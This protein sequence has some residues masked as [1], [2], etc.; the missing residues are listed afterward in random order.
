MQ[1]EARSY[2]LTVDADGRSA[3]ACELTES[4]IH[5]EESAAARKLVAQHTHVNELM[6]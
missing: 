4:L 2:S 6:P 3:S 5:C 1:R